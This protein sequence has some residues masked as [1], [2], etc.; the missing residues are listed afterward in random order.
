MFLFIK[1]NIL[2]KHDEEKNVFYFSGHLRLELNLSVIWDIIEEMKESEAVYLYYV[3]ALLQQ[4]KRHIRMREVV[5][6]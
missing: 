6:S 5:A 3:Y 2:K 4:A 1:R